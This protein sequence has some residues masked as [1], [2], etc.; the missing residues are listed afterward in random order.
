MLRFIYN[1][2][3]W[4]SKSIDLNKYKIIFPQ[5]RKKKRNSRIDQKFGLEDFS[6]V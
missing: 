3:K 1:G 6:A 5:K 4:R 2:M